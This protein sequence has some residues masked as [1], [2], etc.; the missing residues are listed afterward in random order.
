M[1]IVVAI[2]IGAAM[3]FAVGWIFYSGLFTGNGP[4]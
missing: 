2:I 3:L 1:D 4:K